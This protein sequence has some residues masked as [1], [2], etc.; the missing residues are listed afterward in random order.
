M[1]K[2]IICT[3]GPVSENVKILKHFKKCNVDLFRINLSHTKFDDLEKKI[4]FLK[5]N[6]GINKIC[7]DTEGAQI[8]TGKIIKPRK[9]KQNQIVTMGFDN[10][11]NYLLY[12]YFEIIKLKVGTKA[13]IG[14]DDLAVKIISKS[15]NM[16][17]CKVI[18]PG[19]IESNKGV[20][21]ETNVNLNTLT[22][23]D[24]NCINL[25]LKLGVKNFALSFANKPSDI[26]TIRKL[27]KKNCKLISKIET[28]NA[29]K[30]LYQII[31]KSDAVLIDRG[32]LSRY[33]PVF[34]IPVEQLKIL[35]VS[36][37]LKTPTYIATNLLETM[38]TKPTPTRA[39]SN[40]I[41][42]SLLHGASGLVLAAETAIGKYPKECVNFLKKS[43]SEYNK[44]LKSK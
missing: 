30:N 33:I 17:K 28:K 43:I 16:I 44:F 31:K 39:E 41:F 27:I 25:A 13:Q 5:K 20:H 6:I 35:K 36:K 12:P 26:Q 24:I 3:I 2:K 15:N 40:D 38:V 22:D 8:R 37:K 18:Q 19:L 10:T 7:I 4:N 21:F 9:L 11:A 32:D 42:Q 1:K 29:L 34:Q 14:F 23:K